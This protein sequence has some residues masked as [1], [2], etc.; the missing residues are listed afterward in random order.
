MR[1]HSQG[2]PEG[3]TLNDYVDG[4]LPASERAAVEAHLAACSE[5]RELVAG[6]RAVLTAVSRLKPP[7]PP[8]A[9]WTR[10]ERS[11]RGAGISRTRWTWLAAAAVLMVATF[12]GLRMS[13]VWP[14]PAATT[15]ATIPASD[16]AYVQ[17]E[18]MA[19][20]QHYQNVISTLERAAGEKGSLD[21]QTASTLE[22]SLA[23][24]DQAINESRAALKAQPDSEPAQ[25]SL[26]ENFKSKIALLQDTVALINDMRKGNEAGTG[27]V[28][29]GL[30]QKGS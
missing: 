5:C 27:R 18:A 7:E 22:K 21:P 4:A 16:A 14:R 28:S 25:Q 9:A 13:G 2:H 1:Q 19:A 15:A 11:I 24:V 23:A 29:A 10:I 6:L 8:A 3:V 26:L 12:A 17:A 30:K 20:E